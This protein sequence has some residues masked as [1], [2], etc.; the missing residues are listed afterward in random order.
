MTN[1]ST[2]YASYVGSRDGVG[3]ELYDLNDR[4]VL[5]VYRDDE[6]QKVSVVTIDEAE[7]PVDVVMGFIQSA[8]SELANWPTEPA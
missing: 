1:Y 2:K 3:V 5:Q 8:L 6:T 4:L 7:I